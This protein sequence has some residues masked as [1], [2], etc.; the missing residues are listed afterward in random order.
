MPER[1]FHKYHDSHDNCMPQPGGYTR[2]ATIGP[3]PIS[4]EP[5]QSST[6]ERG[7]RDF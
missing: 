5:Q 3:T 1:S 4:T 2:D 6:V 7:R